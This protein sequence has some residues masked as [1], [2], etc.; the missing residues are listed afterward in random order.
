MNAFI[1]VVLCTKSDRK[2]KSPVKICCTSDP[3]ESKNSSS[4][5]KLKFHKDMEKDAFGRDPRK[6]TLQWMDAAKE[7]LSSPD[8]QNAQKSSKVSKSHDA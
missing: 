3:N 5:S 4:D 7:V 2:Q 1:P 8:V 6:E